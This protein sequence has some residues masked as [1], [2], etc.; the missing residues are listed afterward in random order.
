MLADNSLQNQ[1][2]R[3]RSGNPTAGSLAGATRRRGWPRALLKREARIALPPI[4]EVAHLPAA[5][6][7]IAAAVAQGAPTA[8]EAEALG[9]LIETFARVFEAGD[10]DARL[11]EVEASLAAAV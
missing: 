2:K 4:R 3:G 9:R 6:L 10:F 8:G 1:Q 7:A 5:M 11:K